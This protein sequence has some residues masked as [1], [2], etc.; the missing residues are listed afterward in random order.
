MLELDGMNMTAL[1]KYASEYCIDK[2]WESIFAEAVHL[3]VAENNSK[4]MYFSIFLLG[5]IS[6]YNMEIL[7]F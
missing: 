3:Y 5:E 4:Q 6:P 7:D 1:R 2:N